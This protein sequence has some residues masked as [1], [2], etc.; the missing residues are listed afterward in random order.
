MENT[1]EKKPVSFDAD[2]YATVLVK[3]TTRIRKPKVWEA[4]VKAGPVKTIVAMFA[5]PGRASDFINGRS[6]DGPF[7][8]EEE[9][10]DMHI[11][12]IRVF[13]T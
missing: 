13:L 10:S 9:R 6:G 8:T 4:V 12:E 5:R 11:V 2:D 7:F 3:T 1:R